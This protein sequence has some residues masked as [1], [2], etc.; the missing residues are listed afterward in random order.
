[1]KRENESYFGWWVRINKEAKQ[2]ADELQR[3]F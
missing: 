2:G 1:M 3:T